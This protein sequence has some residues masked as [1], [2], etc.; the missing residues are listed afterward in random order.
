MNENVWK[1]EKPHMIVRVVNITVTARS[2]RPPI[3]ICEVD[4]II[5]QDANKR[6]C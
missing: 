2:H 1:V 6:S 4:K 5:S 3:A